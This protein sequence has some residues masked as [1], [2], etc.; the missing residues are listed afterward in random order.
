MNIVSLILAVSLMIVEVKQASFCLGCENATLD[1][2]WEMEI[3]CIEMSK[4]RFKS[5]AKINRLKITIQFE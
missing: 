1:L 2:Q 4:Q 3:C 5:S